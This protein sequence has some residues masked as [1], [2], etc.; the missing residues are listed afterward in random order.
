MPKIKGEKLG[1][2]LD[3]GGCPN[4]C[5]HCYLGSGDNR[6]MTKADLRWM[7]GQLRD[8]VKSASVAASLNIT[9]SFRE[10]DFLDDYRSLYELECEL[11]DEIPERYELLSV[12]RLARDKDYAAWA[13]SVG[14]DTCQITLFGM[15]AT[16]D[17]FYRRKSAFKDAL[18]ATERLLETGMK[19]RWQL[20]L[21]K[22]LIPEVNDLLKLIE[23]LKL[24]ERVR[25][26]GAE[27]QVFLHTPDPLHEAVKIENLRPT[28]EEVAS[29]PQEL[30][31]ASRK[32]LGRHILWRTEEELYKSIVTNEQ[33]PPADEGLL[34]QP[35]RL[36][37]FV[38]NNWDVFSNVGTLELWWK[39]GNLKKDSVEAILQR[40]ERDEAPGLDVLYHYPQSKLAEKYGNPQGRK[41]YS[42]KEDL[43]DLYRARHC[44]NIPQ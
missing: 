43:L 30:L 22:K 19:P 12:W 15:E 29:L 21:T 9:A 23:R 34:T 2:A 28:L 1:V 7:A 20:I 11:S 25:E 24:R 44:G 5:R 37:F 39:L 6:K 10:P 32:H 33:K 3:M 18:A 13:K 4:R 42:G 14:P 8:Y 17:W 40:F 31:E 36:W 38:T 41:I 16:T 26:L 27:F 35:T